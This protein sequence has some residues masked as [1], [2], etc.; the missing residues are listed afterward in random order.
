MLNVV[1]FINS[2]NIYILCENIFENISF[3]TRL[4]KLKNEKLIEGDRRRLYLYET[5]NKHDKFRREWWAGKKNNEN[6]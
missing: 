2:K 5:N 1:T 3:Y 4:Q 6:I